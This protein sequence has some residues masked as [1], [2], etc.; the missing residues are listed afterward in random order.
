MEL[1]ERPLIVPKDFLPMLFSDLLI[2]FA[3]SLLIF[4]LRALVAIFISA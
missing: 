2:F 3:S 4:S 1:F